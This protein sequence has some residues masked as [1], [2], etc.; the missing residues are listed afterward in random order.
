MMRLLSPVAGESTD[1]DRPPRRARLVRLDLQHR[2]DLVHAR[3]RRASSSC[4]AS[5]PRAAHQGH[6]RPRPDQAPDPLGGRRR[7]GQQAGRGQPRQGAPVRR[8]ARGLAVLLH[9]DR[10]LARARAQR[11]N[12]DTAPAARADRRHQPDLRARAAHDRQRLGL[13]HPQEGLE[14]LLQALPRALPGAAPAQHPRGD[15]QADHAG[16]ATLRQHLR[17]RHHARADRPD[18][19]LPALGARTSSGRRST[20]S[21]ASSRPS[22][23]PC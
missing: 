14:G 4:S 6:R 5:W 23:S 16:P 10:Q 9:P 11:A 8:A 3:R 21:S 18:A 22:S 1:R 20:C 12:D 15:R 7:R 2:H 19:R 17:R 13:R